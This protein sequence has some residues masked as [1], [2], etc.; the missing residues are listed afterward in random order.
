MLEA[1]AV[2]GLCQLLEHHIVVLDQSQR[3]LGDLLQ[4]DN[5][6]ASSQGLSDALNMTAMSTGMAPMV[7]CRHGSEIEPTGC[8]LAFAAVV[9][10]YSALV[11][12][13]SAAACLVQAD[14][15]TCQQ[16]WTTR[17]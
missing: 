2:Q 8:L 6:D 12:A 4:A 9:F 7:C 5:A 15:A 16:L 11:L 3:P 10:S 14:A 13:G 17:Q 1:Q